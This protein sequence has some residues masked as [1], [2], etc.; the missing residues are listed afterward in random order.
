MREIRALIRE[1]G[2][3]RSVILST[4]ILSEVETVCDRVQIMHRGRMVFNDSIDGLKQKQTSL[5]EVFSQLTLG[6]E[7][8]GDVQA[9]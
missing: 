7:S 2:A 3:E 1:L 5:E 9:S 6:E 4:H 8:S